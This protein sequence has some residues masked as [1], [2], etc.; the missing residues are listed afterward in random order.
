MSTLAVNRAMF[1]LVAAY[2]RAVVAHYRIVTWLMS[3]RQ[4]D[5]VAVGMPPNGARHNQRCGTSHGAIPDVVSE[6]ETTIPL[7]HIS[8]IDHGADHE[9]V[10]PLI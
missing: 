2:L 9:S 8:A 1:H 6:R 10:L 5:I 3:C 7:R 4:S